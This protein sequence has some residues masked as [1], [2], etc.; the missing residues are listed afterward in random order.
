MIHVPALFLFDT[1]DGPK[2]VSQ[3]VMKPT[4][5]RCGQILSTLFSAN[6]EDAAV[7]FVDVLLQHG[8]TE[9]LDVQAEF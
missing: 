5:Q 2:T 8:D 1:R 9:D 4:W 3:P 6:I 7:D